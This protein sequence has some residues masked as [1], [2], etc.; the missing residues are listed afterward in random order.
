[1]ETNFAQFNPTEGIGIPFIGVY[2]FG[3]IAQKVI[4]QSNLPIP[5]KFFSHLWH[6]GCGVGAGVVFGVGAT[7]IICFSGIGKG[8]VSGVGAGDGS[9]IG[10]CVGSGIG[11]GIGSGIGGGDGS[12]IGAGDGCCIGAGNGCPVGAGIVAGDGCAIGAGIGAGDG[13]GMGAG[14]ISTKGASRAVRRNVLRD[15][16]KVPF[17]ADLTTSS[18]TNVH[19]TWTGV[20]ISFIAW[21]AITA[22]YVIVD[23]VSSY[24]RTLAKQSAYVL[25]CHPS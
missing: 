8:V 22:L 11:A 16:T 15:C 5:N 2:T 9:G 6:R 3:Y 19:S 4:L 25:H 21:R 20:F 24:A 12:G 14:I 10:A 18:L 7:T 13:C 23:W 17:R 1:M